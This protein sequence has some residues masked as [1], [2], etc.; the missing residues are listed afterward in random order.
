VRAT[1][2]AVEKKEVLH[3]VMCVFVSLGIQHAKRTL[4][5]VISGLSGSTVLFPHYLTKARFRRK[6]L[7]KKSTFD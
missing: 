1:I 5:F 7:N 6:L 3:I 2:V 4:H